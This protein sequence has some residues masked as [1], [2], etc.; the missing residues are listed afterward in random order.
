VSVRAAAGWLGVSA[1]TLYRAIAE[2]RTPVQVIRV[3]SR[4]VVSTASLRDVLGLGGGPWDDRLGADGEAS[5]FELKATEL[6]SARP[7]GHQGTCR[8]EAREVDRGSH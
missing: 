4:V 1:A 5:T 3:G 8:E 2:G 6:A 7:S